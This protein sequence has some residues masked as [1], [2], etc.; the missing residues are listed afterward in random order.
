VIGSGPWPVRIGVRDGAG[1]YYL[2]EAGEVPSSG[3]WRPG[4]A[5]RRHL[6][7]SGAEAARQTFTMVRLSFDAP[8]APPGAALLVDGV[9]RPEASV[10]PGRFELELALADG[11]EIRLALAEP[12]GDGR[13]LVRHGLA[14]QREG[15]ELRWA[16][17]P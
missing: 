17:R 3:R 8:T 15:T 13:L 9:H 12:H 14:L 2:D 11:D 10:E 16:A 4:V 6:R 1:S 5:P 7:V